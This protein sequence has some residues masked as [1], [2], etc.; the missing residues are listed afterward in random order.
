[1]DK[2]NFVKKIAAKLNL[3]KVAAEMLLDDIIDLLTDAIAQEKNIKLMNLGTFQVKQKAARHC[4][5]PRTKE[6]IL[7]PAK[8]CVQFNASKKLIGKIK[9]K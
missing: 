6:R 5:N 2:K 3:K 8:K 4:V 9:T 1:M 7:I